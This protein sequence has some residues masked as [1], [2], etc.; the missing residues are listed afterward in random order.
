[1]KFLPNSAF[2]LAAAVFALG[3]HAQ[4]LTGTLK[5]IKDTRHDYAGRAR[6][7]GRAGLHAR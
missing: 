7:V 4:D 3:A 1:M 6:V 5:K 2:I